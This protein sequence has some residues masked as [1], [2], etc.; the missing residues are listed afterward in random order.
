MSLDWG[1]R[2]SLLKHWG[3]YCMLV[4][5]RIVFILWISSEKDIRV[6][7][8]TLCCACNILH[9]DFWF[10]FLICF[11]QLRRK[12]VTQETTTEAELF[13]EVISHCRS[14]RL[15]IYSP[16]AEKHS[17]RN[18]WNANAIF[19]IEEPLV[20]T[21]VFYRPENS[22][23]GNFIAEKPFQSNADNHKHVFLCGPRCS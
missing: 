3:S 4:E 13:A 5:F 22:F 17:W 12:L 10:F 19:Y 21:I 14:N 11:H 6:T 18:K 2:A 1:P 16:L 9:L 20:L 8:T 7:C 23:Y 15:L